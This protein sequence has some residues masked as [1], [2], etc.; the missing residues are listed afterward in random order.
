MSNCLILV[1]HTSHVMAGFQPSKDYQAVILL[2]RDKNQEYATRY[3]GSAASI[4]HLEYNMERI[5]IE[6][7]RLHAELRM[8][9]H[10][11]TVYAAYSPIGLKLESGMDE[12]IRGL[13]ANCIAPISL[14]SDISKRHEK[15]IVNGVFV[16]SIYAHLAPKA[17]NYIYDSEINPLYYGVSKAGV[18][19]GLRWL[20]AQNQL[21]SFNS[22]AL[23]PIPREEVIEESPFLV[24]RLI[25]SMPSGRLVKHKDLHDLI[26]MLLSQHGSLRGQSVFLDGG[27]SIW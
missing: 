11:D 1:G 4:I 26:N 17:S 23:G 13:S 3:S 19:Q 25:E 10:I 2:G 6:S 24:S 7:E 20:S 5:F 12:T 16:S 14:F 15:K 21:H 8:H 27:Y 22:I 18:E 9:D